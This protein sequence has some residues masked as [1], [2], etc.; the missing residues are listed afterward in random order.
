LK[1]KE[2]CPSGDKCPYYSKNIEE[3]E[4]N[5]S[6]IAKLNSLTNMEAIGLAQWAIGENDLPPAIDIEAKMKEI[7]GLEIY[8]KDLEIETEI[9]K[10][11][12]DLEDRKIRIENIKRQKETAEKSTSR[13]E[14][15]RITNELISNKQNRDTYITEITRAMASI[16]GI[17]KN[18][19]EIKIT[20]TKIKTI[21]EKELVLID[22][23]I[24]KVSLIKDAFGSKGIETMVID[25]ILPKLEDRI[26]Q[27]LS[28]LSDFRVR[29][30]TQKKS[31]DGEGIIEGLF[32]TIL[33]EMN[34]EMPFEAYSGG[35][36]LKISVSISEALAIL[37][38]VGFRLFDETFIGL[39]ENS[40][41]SF[42]SV[43]DGLRKEFSQVL[44]ISHLL[45][46]KELFD[47]RLLIIK[48]NN[49]SYVK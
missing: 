1:K 24:R 43:L 7:E 9:P 12:N 2:S 15:D 16:E 21:K 49:I 42:A 34:E 14:I 6:N 19:E 29:L 23:K 30:D 28:Q 37:Q 45:Q 27:V 39:D 38:K 40:T 22:E 11:E 17:D 46:I 18:E 33:N 20:K 4:F 41:E 13:E 32:I 44:C 35:E 10:L 36:K 25:Y 26:N 3:I 48:N 8:I 47:K 31:V 5:I